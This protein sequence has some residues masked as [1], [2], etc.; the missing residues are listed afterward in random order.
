MDRIKQ[1]VPIGHTLYSQGSLTQVSQSSIR[2]FPL[3][4][5]RSTYLL[6]IRRVWVIKR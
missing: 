2:G 6:T 3:L 4:Q 5:G 1:Y